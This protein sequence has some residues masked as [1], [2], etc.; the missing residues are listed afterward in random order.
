MKSVLLIIHLVFAVSLA[1]LILLQSSKG[2]FA[3]GLGAGEF[4]RSRRGAERLVFIA[5]FV[6]ASLFLVTSL[7]NL[8]VR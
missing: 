7:A 5:T 6:L 8:L 2:G 4:Y 3:S 1:G